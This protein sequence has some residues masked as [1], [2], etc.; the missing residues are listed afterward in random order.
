MVRFVGSE[1]QCA[2][3][4]TLI[5][6]STPPIIP[7]YRLAVQ[8]GLRGIKTF[9]D[10]SDI[11]DIVD[12]TPFVHEQAPRAFSKKMEGLMVA[13]ERLYVT[14]SQQAFET[15]GLNVEEHRL[16]DEG[17]NELDNDVEHACKRRWKEAAQ[18]PTQNTE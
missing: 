4:G 6:F 12:V 7:T 3:N 5:I 1:E 8:L 18:K 17:E 10:G 11:I 14:G 13:S 9:G 15:I 16:E 2:Y